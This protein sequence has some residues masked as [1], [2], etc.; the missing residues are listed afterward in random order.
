VNLYRSVQDGAGADDV[1]AKLL[2]DDVDLV[3]FTSA[4]AVRAFVSAVGD[5]AAKR[6]KAASIGP[7]TSEAIRAAGLEIAVEADVATMNGLVDAI[8]DHYAVLAG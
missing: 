2:D 8:C 4:S 3:T 5:D 6:V 7:V 1:R